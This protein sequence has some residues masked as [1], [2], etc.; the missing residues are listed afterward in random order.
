MARKYVRGYV[1]DDIKV[2]V[3]IKEKCDKDGSY[4]MI[5]KI[6][7]IH[8]VEAIV[9]NKEG[10]KIGFALYCLDKKCEYEYDGGKIEIIAENDNGESKEKTS[11]IGRNK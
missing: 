5:R 10:K 6:H 4:A 9:Y 1:I 3:K 8:N 2:G 11:G 7:D